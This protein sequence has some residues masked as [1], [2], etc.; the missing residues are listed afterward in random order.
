MLQHGGLSRLPL[1]LADCQ[2]FTLRSLCIAQRAG[3]AGDGKKGATI[4]LAVPL[5]V[6]SRLA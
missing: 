2:S 4:H 6:G 3:E 5:T 1:R